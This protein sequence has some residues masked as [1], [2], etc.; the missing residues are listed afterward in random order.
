VVTAER[1]E[2][3]LPALVK[4]RQSPRHEDNLVRQP[5]PCL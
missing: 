5:G 2:M 4:T 3:T 1:D